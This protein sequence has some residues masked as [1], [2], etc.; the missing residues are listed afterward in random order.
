MVFAPFVTFQIKQRDFGWIMWRGNELHVRTPGVG[1]HGREELLLGK[2]KQAGL[3]Y[4]KD[5]FVN[6]ITQ[7]H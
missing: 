6:G 7:W 2:E 1:G 4:Y 5:L 3:G